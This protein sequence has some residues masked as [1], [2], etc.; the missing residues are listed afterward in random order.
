MILWNSGNLNATNLSQDDASVLIPWLSF[1]VPGLDPRGLYLSGDG[2]AESIVIEQTSAPAALSLLNDYC[3]VDFLC[4]RVGDSN[5]PSGS[6]D[7]TTRCIDL[8]PLGSARVAG[9]LMGG[10]S[11][12]HQGQGS[13]CY[14]QRA[15]DVLGPRA[16]ALGAP[17]G[18]EN[19]VGAIKGIASYASITN[20]VSGG[21]DYRTVV[22]GV[23]LHWRRDVGD[24]ES[25]AGQTPEPAVEQRLREVLAWFGGL[26]AESCEDLSGIVSVPPGG[27]PPVR[28]QLG[29]RILT[30]NP[31]MGSARA[32]FE[33]T[34]P[35]GQTAR[36]Q[37]FDVAG[38]LIRTLHDGP[39]ESTV[40]RVG[41]DRTDTAGRQVP[42]GIYFL[43]LAGEKVISKRLVVIR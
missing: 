11:V 2:L 8:T 22:D 37:V 16:G 25:I 14:E 1:T 34:V 20:I 12:Q 29:L 6:V 26:S 23:S 31:V 36:L 4:G 21:P 19:Y 27:E 41:W 32:E 15:F 7:D 33:L 3:G 5:C 40:L 28:P 43:R 9:L 39:A 18:D 30:A 13:G 10:R 38:R 17:Q 42:S 24:C 35:E